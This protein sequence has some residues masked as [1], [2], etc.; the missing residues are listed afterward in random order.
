[1]N[2]DSGHPLTLST[3]ISGTVQATSAARDLILVCSA[4]DASPISDIAVL[5]EGLSEAVSRSCSVMP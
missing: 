3:I 4:G 1:M 2:R 5:L